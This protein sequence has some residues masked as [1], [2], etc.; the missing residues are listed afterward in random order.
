MTEVSPIFIIG[1]GRSGTSLL[2]SMLGAHS[3]IGFLPETQFLR[4]YCFSKKTRQK[5]ERNERSSFVKALREDQAFNRLNLDPE[6]CVPET[7]FTVYD[8]YDNILKC[9]LTKLDKTIPGD[10]DPRNLDFIKEIH[11]HFP[12]ALVV[13][14][15]RDPRD[16]VLSRTK[17][18][19]SKHWPFFLHACMYNT[20]L[21]RGRKLTAQLFKE[22]YQEVY[23]EDL[24]QQPEL[25][26]KR[27]CQGI[28][29]S[30]DQQML[31]YQETAKKLVSQSEMQWKKETTGPLLRKNTQKW[32]QAFSPYQN[33]LIERICR[34]VWSEL[35]YHKSKKGLLSIIQWMKIGFYVLLSK[36]FDWLYPLRL[37][38]LS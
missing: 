6:D 31:H 17:A 5:I 15:I 18:D 35:P 3:E 25:E 20:Q 16:V 29:V 22:N 1:V 38:F 13:H 8:V 19:W 27:L 33:V 9:Y 10:K 32:K 37:K 26:L 2:Q 14:I 30:F 23:Y 7:S 24:L 36:I 12:Q 28:N 34:P 21:K 4:K 11:K